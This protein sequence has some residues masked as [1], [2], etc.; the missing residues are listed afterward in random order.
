MPSILP[1][2]PSL[3]N[4]K[5]PSRSPDTPSPPHAP[6]L[7]ALLAQS[8]LFFFSSLSPSRPARLFPTAAFALPAPAAGTLS[9]VGNLAN[10]VPNPETFPS[11]SMIHSG[12][13]ASLPR[14]SE[15]PRVLVGAG[16]VLDLWN[17]EEREGTWR[18]RR[19][20]AMREEREEEEVRGE[21]VAEEGKGRKEVEG[22]GVVELFLRSEEHT[23]GLQSQ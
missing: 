7:P 18:T 15:N 19:V 23:S 1:R 14:T 10:A 20:A 5:K 6:V 2:S 22:A 4:P 8:E 17:E 3:L 16:R 21:G 11:L 13:L 9:L 12:S